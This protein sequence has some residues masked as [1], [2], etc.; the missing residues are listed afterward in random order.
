M[1]CTMYVFDDKVEKMDEVIRLGNSAW[2][3][4]KI[5]GQLDQRPGTIH[6]LLLNDRKTNC[7]P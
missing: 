1:N 6:P 2:C 7:H 5:D 3:H 4:D